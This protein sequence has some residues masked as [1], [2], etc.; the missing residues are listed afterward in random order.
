MSAAVAAKASATMEKVF[1]LASAS[2]LG[3]LSSQTQAEEMEQDGDCRKDQ[4]QA[5][6]ITHQTTI[7]IEEPPLQQVVPVGLAVGEKASNMGMRPHRLE[8]SGS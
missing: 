1:G 2:H 7:E 4:D 5:E 8:P 6:A 3:F